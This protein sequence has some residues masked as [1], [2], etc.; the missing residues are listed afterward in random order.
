[1]ELTNK[2]LSIS[3]KNPFF[4]FFLSK[5]RKRGVQRQRR[6]ISVQGLQRQ[7]A[8]VTQ[9]FPSSDMIRLDVTIWRF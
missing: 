3:H 5:E 4:F 8:H 7:E 6:L 1:M 9:F 2:M